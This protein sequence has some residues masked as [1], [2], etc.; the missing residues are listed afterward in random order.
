MQRRDRAIVIRMQILKHEDDNWN[1]EFENAFNRGLISGDGWRALL[2]GRLP[3]PMRTESLN[4]H[5]EVFLNACRRRHYQ[6][7]LDVWVDGLGKVLSTQWD[8][9]KFRLI[10]LIRGEWETRCFGLPS[11]KSKRSPYYCD[12][13]R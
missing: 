3:R 13:L 5:R 2:W 4:E 1:F 12:V 11:P 6:H 7:C 9:T 8:G 10:C